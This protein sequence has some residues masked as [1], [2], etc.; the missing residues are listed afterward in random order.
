M[1]D[2]NNS[3]PEL[4]YDAWRDTC[5]TLHLW[6]QVVGKIR[7]ATTP[8]VNHGWHVPLYV[9]GRGLSTS[10]MPHGVRMFTMQ[11]DFREHVLD[12]DVSDG[13]RRTIVLEPQSVAQFK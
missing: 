5:T 12:I 11:F 10:A 3:W 8:W 9:N 2:A 4:H 13:Q 7:L 1:P 6:T